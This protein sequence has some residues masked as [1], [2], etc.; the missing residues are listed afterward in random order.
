MHWRLGWLAVLLVLACSAPRAAPQGGWT[1]NPTEPWKLTATAEA[2]T[3]GAERA[4][5]AAPT[6]TRAPAVPK[7]APKPA[8]PVGAAAYT[9]RDIQDVT[10][11]G[12]VRFRANAIIPN[13]GD[14]D[15]ATATLADAARRL[16]RERPNAQAVMI[17]GYR[18]AAET[19]SAFTVGRAEASR[20]GRGWAGDGFFN[21]PDNNQIHITLGNANELGRQERRQI[22][23]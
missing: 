23:R 14:D 11:P 22:P 7:P 6:A 5:V 13:P 19:N 2:G 18:T 21:G 10:Y 9:L 1:P 4:Q 3:I 17:F 12:R 20:D 8:G 16:L 15:V